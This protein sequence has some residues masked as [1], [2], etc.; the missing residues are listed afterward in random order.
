MSLIY[1]DKNDNKDKNKSEK[2]ESK[3]IEYNLPEVTISGGF[4]EPSRIRNQNQVIKEQKPKENYSIVDKSLNKIFYYNKDGSIIKSEDIIS[5]KSNND[6][7]KGLSMKEWFKKTGSDNH[8]DYFK[9]L[10]ENKYQTT[11]SGIYTI[12]GLKENVAEDPNKLGKLINFFRPERREKIYNDRLRD[13]G[14]DQKLLTLKSEFNVGSSKAIHGTANEARVKA[15]N[16]LNAD[17]NLSNGCINVGG[18]TLCFNTLNKG[19]LVYIL[20]EESNEILKPSADYIKK[21]LKNVNVKNVLNTKKQIIESLKKSNIPIDESEVDFLTAVAEKETK[22]GRSLNAKLQDYLPDFLAHSKGEFQI[23]PKA[24]AQ[25]LPENY[26]GSFDDQVKAVSNF[27]KKNVKKESSKNT[28]F[29]IFEN[30]VMSDYETPEDLYQKYS[31]D[32]K[33]KY[34]DTFNKFYL[35]A[36]HGYKKGGSLLYKKKYK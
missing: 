26:S 8:E 22:G 33:G 4:Y 19:S 31:G 14:T 10:E 16:T 36:L 18:E 17:K 7:D 3:P 35:A 34:N 25:Y 15:F 29:P 30:T 27:Y 24:F 20:P 9:Y 1:K 5:G 21:K 11:P 13:Y 6:I 2:K 32:K 12:S 23:N 28:T